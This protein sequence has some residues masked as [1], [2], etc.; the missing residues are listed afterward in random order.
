VPHVGPSL[1]ELRRIF[2]AAPTTYHAAR[3][4][5]AVRKAALADRIK[6]SDVVKHLHEIAENVPGSTLKFLLTSE[7]R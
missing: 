2:V 7:V 3:L 6:A 4:H 5:D 1:D